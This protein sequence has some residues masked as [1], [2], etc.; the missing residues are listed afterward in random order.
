MED[1]AFVA[2][3]KTAFYFDKLFKYK[4]PKRLKGDVDIFSRVLVPFGA[5]NRTRQGMV[6]KL[7]EDES[8]DGLKDIIEVLETLQNISG[9]ILQLINHLHTTCFCT[10]YEALKTVFPVGLSY[11][12][13]DEFHWREGIKVEGV[14]KVVKE[15]ADKIDKSAASKRKEIFLKLNSSVKE[16]LLKVKKAEFVNKTKRN[17][18]DKTVRMLRAV[19]DCSMDVCGLSTKQ[20]KV[21]DFLEE[22]KTASVKET[23]YYCGV[24]SAVINNMIKKGIIS[25]YDK[26]SLRRPIEYQKTKN[27]DD[28]QL[29]DEQSV[30]AQRLNELRKQKSKNVSLLRGI[31]GSGKTI[32]YLKLI[33]Y[34]VKEGKDAILLVPEISLTPQLVDFFNSYFGDQIAILHSGLTMGEKL[35][36]YKRILRQEAKIVIGTRSAVFAPVNNLGLII[37]DEE[38]ESSYKNA[39]MSPR[40]HARDVAKYRCFKSKALLILASATPSVESEY[41][42]KRG[43]YEFFELKHRYK[44]AVLP[45]VILADRRIYPTSLVEGVSLPLFEEIENNINNSEQSILLLN[46]R[47]YNSNAFCIDCGFVKQCDNCSAA[48][49]YHKAN[50]SLV[51]H[52]CG[53]IKAP[54]R[55]CP[56]CG[57]K[58]MMYGGVGTQ[59]VEEDLK[60]SFPSAKILRMDA[61]TTFSRPDLEN[62]IKVFEK[63]EYDILIGTQI[64][65]KGLNF[66]NVTL[67]GVLSAD[68][69]LYGADFRCRERL[70]SMLTQVVGRSGRGNK[71]GRA[72]IQT[73]RPEN[74]VIVQAANQDYNSF[75]QDEIKERRS[76]FCPPFCDLC[77]IGFSGLNEQTTLKAAEY[78]LKEC[79][80]YAQK[81]VPIIVLGI[82]SPYIF[83]LSNRYRKRIIL[84]CKANKQFLFWMKRVS[85]E[86]LKDRIFSNIRVSIDING[87][88]T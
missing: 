58:H 42:A 76:F 88:I 56:L 22:T 59:K 46:R 48:M 69:L 15:A 5:G 62:Q 18:Y 2:V 36:E 43:K 82:S 9:D 6:L 83:K 33:Q 53:L 54:L 13:E 60:K 12:I 71:K 79:R 74:A 29:T 34:A 65:A 87:E 70:F 63:G 28:I 61:D 30:V 41:N 39:D 31:T 64:V 81:S 75:F 35:D 14:P 84:K 73:Y 27:I 21:Y 44:N 26:E 16:E 25:S 49:T 3:E 1:V 37:M 50:D 11:K 77:S 52:Y 80:K 19:S 51:C 23:C 57:G 72:V 55:K 66:P 24:T 40:Y 68:S 17:A 8:A 7:G 85:R 45:E 10:W 78:F 86:I 38:G 47:G 20:K 4:I 67:V 32:I